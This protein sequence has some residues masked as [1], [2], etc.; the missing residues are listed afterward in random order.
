MARELV[1]HVGTFKTGTTSFQH[2]ALRNRDNLWAQGIDYPDAT[3]AFGSR[4]PQ[5]HHRL[6]LE[7]AR[8]PSGAGKRARRY[9]KR[10]K[11]MPWQ[12]HR[13]LISSEMFS[14]HVAGRDLMRAHMF[15]E[16][17][18]ERRREYVEAIA[19][20]LR[21]FDVSVVMVVRRQDSF[22][23][24]QYNEA[25]KSRRPG[26]EFEEIQYRGD[27]A[28]YL[29]QG[30]VL[31]HYDRQIALYEE[32]VGPVTVLRFEDGDTIQNL[33]SAVGMTFDPALEVER[34]NEKTDARVSLWLQNFEG[35]TTKQREWFGRS[36]EARA[37][38]PDFGEPTV[39]Q[40]AQQREA[41]LATFAGDR[42]GGDYFSAPGPLGKPAKLTAADAK[43]IAAAYEAWVALPGHAELV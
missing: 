8:D 19:R 43:R 32:I 25:V 37:L 20:M 34:R 13:V 38:F 14:G 16:D 36:S 18:W 2:A 9:R 33:C 21:G 26:L 5:V 39:W 23:E 10:L 24:S 30:G 3:E 15:K 27:F 31:A 7:V 12:K 28:A 4:L 40:S 22:I 29:D 41:F 6:A 35:G 42:Y 17:Y 11:G 1:L